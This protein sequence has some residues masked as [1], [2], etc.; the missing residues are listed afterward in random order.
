MRAINHAFS[1]AVIGL[2]IVN[3]VISLPLAFMSHFVVD[4]I[5]HFG[6]NGSEDVNSKWFNRTLLADAV[7]CVILVV[8]LFAARPQHWLTASVGAFLATSPDLMWIPN[9]L[10]IRGGK[11]ARTNQS[12]VVRFHAWIQW[13]E[14]PIGIVTELAWFVAG[15]IVI[16]AFIG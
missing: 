14:H 4:A 1:G 6:I 9:Y 5:P 10:R 2:T 16:A 13:F 8:V 11:V 12:I 15:I 7:L 3:P